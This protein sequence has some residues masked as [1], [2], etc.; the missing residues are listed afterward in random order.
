MPGG[1][2]RRVGRLAKPPAGDAPA[3]VSKQIADRVLARGRAKKRLPTFREVA[4]SMR[5]TAGRLVGEH[6]DPKSEPWQDWFVDQL[7]SG[8]WTTFYIT[9]PP[10]KS[11]KTTYGMM[12]PMIRTSVF[13]GR[14]FGY[15]MPTL[16]DLARAWL[17]KVKPGYK[18]GYDGHLPTSGPGSKGGRPA[19]VLLQD[20]ESGEAEGSVVFFASTAYGAS[21]QEAAIDEVDQFR[22]RGKPDW[23]GYNNVAARIESFGARGRLYAQGTVEQELDMPEEIEREGSMILRLIAQGSGARLH[24]RCP[25]C[26]EFA[27]IKPDGLTYD[28]TSEATARA[29]ARQACPVA[30]GAMWTEDQRVEAVRR[31]K[32]VHAGQKVQRDGTVI[33]PEPLTQKCS[34]TVTSWDMTLQS[35]ADLADMHRIATADVVR[36]SHENMKKFY[37]YRRCEWYPGGKIGELGVPKLDVEHLEMRAAIEVHRAGGKFGPAWKETDREDGQVPTY[38][39]HWAPIPRTAAFCTRAIDM[40]DDRLYWLMIAVDGDGRWYAVGWGYLYGNHAHDVLSEA[41]R[42]AL[43]DRIDAATA[44]HAACWGVPADAG[45]KASGSGCPIA[46]SAVDANFRTE[47]AKRW[48]AVH[49]EWVP[50]MG[51]GFKKATDIRDAGKSVMDFPGILSR[52]RAVTWML[53]QD[54]FH[55]DTHPMRLKTQRS[56][57]AAPGDVGAGHAPFGLQKNP[58]GRLLF[59][60]FCGEQWDAL[61]KKWVGS[62]RWDL[63]DC[64]VYAYALALMELEMI[65]LGTN[66]AAEAAGSPGAAAP[67]GWVERDTGW[68]G[69]TDR[70]APWVS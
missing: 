70:G 50:V 67:T 64:A 6:M 59:D 69:N 47:E 15:A 58:S 29:T 56:F 21:V 51:A 2:P 9:A 44:R 1:A 20:P 31:G 68:M 61:K 40:Q 49:P 63:L 28:G 41:A 25:A 66:A 57:L 13:L 34:L 37:N 43:L 35:L 36:G 38:S 42:Q 11:G 5:Y 22:V 3:D 19:V 52:K 16:D 23:D 33:G 24:A 62:G 7:D 45:E 12:V 14:P 65:R 4:R 32:F 30:C 27:I 54:L 18:S 55:I 8:R 26:G 48:L 46:W 17:Q 60:H 39:W 53:T 10:Q